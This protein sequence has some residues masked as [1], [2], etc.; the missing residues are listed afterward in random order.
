[1]H[2]ILA[3]PV[4][5]TCALLEAVVWWSTSVSQPS[6]CAP[7]DCCTCVAIECFMVNCVTLLLRNVRYHALFLI[8]HP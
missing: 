4:Y 3:I 6:D 7:S 1:M 2:L 8:G 5:A